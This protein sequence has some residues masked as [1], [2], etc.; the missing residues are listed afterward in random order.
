MRKIGTQTKTDAQSR[1]MLCVS[2]V[3]LCAVC[4]LAQFAKAA[5][6]ELERVRIGYSVGG[7]IPFPII[8]AK[9]NRLFEQ[10]GFDIELINI[11]PTIAVTALVSGDIPYVIFAGTTL[12][13]A[14]RGLP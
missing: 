2:I 12:N 6:K 3:S 14:V 4:V 11:P 13:A 8:V 5:S 10:A 7:L 1:R 9:E